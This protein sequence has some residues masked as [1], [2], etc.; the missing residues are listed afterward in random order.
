MPAYI[1]RHSSLIG[2]YARVKGIELLVHQ[3]IRI[4]NRKCQIVNL[5]AG[6]D[7][8]YWQLSEHS[9][10][11]QLFIEVDFGM[12]TARKCQYIRLATLTCTHPYS[13]TYTYH[14]HPLC[15]YVLLLVMYRYWVC[16]ISRRTKRLLY[17]A[18]QKGEGQDI[19]VCR[20]LFELL[21]TV[22]M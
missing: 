3:F 15:V 21:V 11:P 5:G 8:S 7:T 13:Y 17:E 19:L 14:V 6:F 4:T 18:L 10:N 22:I 2:Y 16:L 1:A 20:S 9:M 12:V